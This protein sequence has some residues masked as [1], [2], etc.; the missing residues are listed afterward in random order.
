MSVLAD[1]HFEIVEAI[2]AAE[3]GSTQERYER[4]RHDGFLD[5]VNI[6]RSS[7]VVGSLLIDADLR[8]LN[9]GIDRPMCGGVWLD[10]PIVRHP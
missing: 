9:Q 8:Y 10:K 2:N 1:K 4:G 5:A 7:T 3:E 6:L